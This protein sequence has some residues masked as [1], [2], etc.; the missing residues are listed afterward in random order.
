MDATD[1]RYPDIDA[2]VSPDFPLDAM[3]DG[4]QDQPKDDA[5]ADGDEDGGVDGP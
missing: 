3:D 4:A 2:G 5:D 1:D